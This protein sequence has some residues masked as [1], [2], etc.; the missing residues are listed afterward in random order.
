MGRN[1]GGKEKRK[2]NKGFYNI[3][4]PSIHISCQI[5]VEIKALTSWWKAVYVPFAVSSC[6]MEM[7]TPF[8][9][10]E[11]AWEAQ[12]LQEAP[13]WRKCQRIYDACW[14]LLIAALQAVGRVEG[15]A[16]DTITPQTGGSRGSCQTTTTIQIGLKHFFFWYVM[17]VFATAHCSL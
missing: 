3:F 10:Q 13:I 8:A 7:N 16:W 14:W 12:G 4:K 9:A 5:E 11:T 15:S 2:Y 6:Q 1:S 17:F